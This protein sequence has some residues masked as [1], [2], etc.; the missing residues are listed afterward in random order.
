MMTPNQ[1]PTIAGELLTGP[2]RGKDDF[3]LLCKV[4]ENSD[5]T[6]ITVEEN[7]PIA[8][9]K[10][11]VRDVILAE[12][13]IKLPTRKEISKGPR[14]NDLT[15]TI[16]WDKM[17]TGAAGAAL[18]V[19]GQEPFQDPMIYLIQN[20]ADK[21]VNPSRFNFPSGLLSDDFLSQA[22]TEITEETGIILVE[23][24]ELIGLNYDLPAHLPSLKQH[25]K[26]AVLDGR[27]AQESCLQEE[28]DLR[29]PEYEGKKVKKWISVPTQLL[30]KGLDSVSFNILGETFNTHAHVLVDEKAKSANVHFP[31]HFDLNNHEFS[32]ILAIDPEKF[33]R[34][35]GLYTLDQALALDTIPAPHDYLLRLKQYL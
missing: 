33:K 31:L 22:F 2:Y 5:G 29:H 30:N 12:T 16:D 17:Y 24:N 27:D 20:S 23:D 28:L 21:P 3:F 32:E 8:V 13:G 15:A 34:N 35:H 1:Y 6:H 7:S 19:S 26:T 4:E 10:E 14:P 11:T 18:W 9:N 25:F